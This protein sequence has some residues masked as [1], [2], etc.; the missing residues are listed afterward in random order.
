M[1]DRC[2]GML[3]TGKAPPC[4]PSFLVAP[5]PTETPGPLRSPP[6]W[7]GRPVPRRPDTATSPSD[8]GRP[9]GRSPTGCRLSCAYLRT[10]ARNA[11]LLQP[12][13]A[14]E[15]IGNPRQGSHPAISD[16]ASAAPAQPFKY[17]R[18]NPFDFQAHAPRN[19]VG[20][21]D[22]TLRHGDLP[23]H[24]YGREDEPARTIMP[25]EP[26]TSMA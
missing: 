8:S 26:P 5:R 21:C 15:V 22:R 13:A 7:T 1:P 23:S 6:P 3:T 11:W 20:Q 14:D 9:C 12:S 25:T 16:P 4:G 18:S 2:A 19:D 10:A 24:A 17:S